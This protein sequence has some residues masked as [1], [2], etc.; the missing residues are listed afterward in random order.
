MIYDIFYYYT[1]TVTEYCQH[2]TIIN[3][4]DEKYLLIVILICN[5]LSEVE[6]HLVIYAL[7]VGCLFSEFLCI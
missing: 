7:A 6:H 5:Y 1:H 3:L 4:T 2:L